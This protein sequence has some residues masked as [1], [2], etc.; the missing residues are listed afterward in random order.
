MVL[1]RHLGGR[2]VGSSG[3][4]SL[5]GCLTHFTFVSWN[6]SLIVMMSA[7][8]ER[9]TPTISMSVSR[10]WQAWFCV[11]DLGG[12]S[13]QVTW[14]ATARLKW[15]QAAS[16]SDARYTSGGIAQGNVIRLLILVLTKTYIC[17]THFNWQDKYHV[18]LPVCKHLPFHPYIT[19]SLDGLQIESSSGI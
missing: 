3:S 12:A 13:S 1:A 10:A 19:Y 18:S 14:E 17:Q 6:S 9:Q 5:Q 8:R 2:R 11:F 4:F 7:A 15:P 16:L